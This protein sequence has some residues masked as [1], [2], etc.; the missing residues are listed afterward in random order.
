MSTNT[1]ITNATALLS[2]PLSNQNSVF[3]NENKIRTLLKDLQVHVK[4]YH[5]ER[6]KSEPNLVN[7][8]KAHEKVKKEEKCKYI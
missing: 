3:V 8:N 2:T 1:T 6:K 5:E 7:I 4:K